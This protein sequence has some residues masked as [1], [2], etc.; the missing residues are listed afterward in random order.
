MPQKARWQDTVRMRS[1]E[2]KPSPSPRSPAPRSKGTSARPEQ[3]VHVVCSIDVGTRNPA[4]TLLEIR[5]E[6]LRVLSVDK[7]DWSTD[8]EHRVARDVCS[9]RADVVL[10]EKQGPRSPHAKF[11]HFMRG[12]LFGQTPVLCRNPALRGGSYRARK[13]RSVQ[14]FLRR[15]SFFGIDTRELRAHSKLD[16]VADSFHMALEYALARAAQAERARESATAR[17]R[18]AGANVAAGFRACPEPLARADTPPHRRR[19]A[20][21]TQASEL[22]VAVRHDRSCV[23][24]AE[25][26][27]RAWHTPKLDAPQR[28]ETFERAGGREH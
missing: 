2:K 21:V 19:R 3:D 22:L 18:Q 7:L 10:V 26:K 28:T 24:Q 20:R 12:L 16:D 4:R 27:E 8:W 11:L 1:P 25:N 23:R 5:G 13:R 17:A 6:H 15:L 9:V 14:L